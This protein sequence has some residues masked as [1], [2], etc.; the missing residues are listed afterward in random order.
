MAYNFAGWP[1]AVVRCG[2]LAEGL[3]I[4]VQVVAALERVLGGRKAPKPL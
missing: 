3:L 1:A 4:A 2:E